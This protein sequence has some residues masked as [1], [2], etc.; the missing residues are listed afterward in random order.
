MAAKGTIAK[1]QVTAK[2][3]EAF[4]ADYVGEV[5]RKLYVWAEEN[6]ERVQVA[7]SLTCPKNPVGADG[8]T[9]TV[10]TPAVLEFG[11]GPAVI[12]DLSEDEKQNIQDLMARL[13]L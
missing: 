13:G 2:I 8:A 4:G 12:P 10:A 9:N 7:L 5:D 3:A 1:Q 6:G 11:D